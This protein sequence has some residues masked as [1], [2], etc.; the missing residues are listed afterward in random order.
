M[1]ASKKGI[2]L[3]FYTESEINEV[4]ETLKTDV[5]SKSN[6]QIIVELANKFNRPVSG[7]EQKIHALARKDS[8]IKEI[9]LSRRKALKARKSEGKQLS[10]PPRRIKVNSLIVKETKALTLPE[11]MTY[12]GTAKKV[13]LHA[14]HFRVYF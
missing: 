12:Q 4:L 11:G 6:L 8:A 13:E 9:L 3:N 10:N 2:K 5:T 14:D 1:K 7:L